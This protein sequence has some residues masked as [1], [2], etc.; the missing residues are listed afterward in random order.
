MLWSD[1]LTGLMQVT[2]EQGSSAEWATAIGTI[3]LAVMTFLAVLAA[4][5]QDRIRSW[6][7]RPELDLRILPQPPDCLKIPMTWPTQGG[8]SQADCYYLRVQVD[9][10]GHQAAKKV[11]LF[12]GEIL[13]K[14][15]SGFARR[16]TFLPLN[17]LWA[18]FREPTMFLDHLSPHVPKHCDVAHIIDPAARTS[19]PGEDNPAL[20]LISQQTALSLDL[21]V[22]PNTFSYLLPPGTYRLKLV[23][24]AANAQPVT[25][26]VEIVHSGQWFSNEQQMLSTGL[27]IRLLDHA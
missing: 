7:W 26:W 10:M 8:M 21:V 6:I 22:K 24:G 15:P 25:R 20:G 9:N 16:Q 11:E 13:E 17:L 4:V 14:T 19:I 1:N 23:L 27:Q 18:N 2:I 5:F 3:A 12:L